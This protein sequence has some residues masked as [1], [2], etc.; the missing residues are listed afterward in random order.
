MRKKQLTAEMPEK[1]TYTKLRP[2]S[3]TKTEI[4]TTS[5]VVL[6]TTVSR[7]GSPMHFTM[8]NE[9]PRKFDVIVNF[10]SNDVNDKKKSTYD[11]FC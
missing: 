6:E 2:L 11:N 4:E 10:G 1:T 5:E 3:F 9:S 8:Y 7:K